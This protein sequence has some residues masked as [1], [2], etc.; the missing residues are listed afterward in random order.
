MRRTDQANGISGRT[1]RGA[2]A[3]RRADD[4]RANGRTRIGDAMSKFATSPVME[5]ANRLD[6]SKSG[7]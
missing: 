6:D 1:L 7:V 2:R 3:T 4:C 5:N